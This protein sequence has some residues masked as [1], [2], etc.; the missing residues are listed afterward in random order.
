MPA[1]DTALRPWLDPA[2]NTEHDIVTTLVGRGSPSIR[3]RDDSGGVTKD[4]AAVVRRYDAGNKTWERSRSRRSRRGLRRVGRDVGRWSRLVAWHQND[5]AATPELRGCGAFT[6]RRRY[7]LVDAGAHSRR[8]S[9]GDVALAVA[10]DGNARVTW[11]ET[12]GTIR[13]LWSATYQVATRPGPRLQRSRPAQ[14]YE[15]S[16]AWPWTH[17]GAHSGLG[18]A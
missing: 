17:A 6:P 18:A 13:S 5:N 4:M 7:D 2:E 11:D 14:S 8:S 3:R 9:L 16:R 1:D 10:R 12:N 15:A